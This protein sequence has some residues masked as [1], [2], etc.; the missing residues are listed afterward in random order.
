MKKLIVK[1]IVNF[2][3]FFKNVCYNGIW[4]DANIRG[5]L[6]PLAGRVAYF[7]IENVVFVI[8]KIP[9]FG[10]DPCVVRVSGIVDVAAV[11]VRCQNAQV[12]INIVDVIFLWRGLVKRTRQVLIDL[13]FAFINRSIQLTYWRV[14]GERSKKRDHIFESKVCATFNVSVLKNKFYK[15]T[16]NHAKFRFV[17]EYLL[18]RYVN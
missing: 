1:S 4:V 16:T 2:G 11:D 17:A 13:A 14:R 3:D 15:W 6:S 7:L 8:V 10:F 18:A 9:N 5:H 12:V